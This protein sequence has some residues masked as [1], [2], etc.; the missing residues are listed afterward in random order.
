MTPGAS[1]GRALLNRTALLE[2]VCNSVGRAFLLASLSTLPSHLFFRH[3][4]HAP[5]PASALLQRIFHP[6]L[7]LIREIS[8][9]L[10]R[11]FKATL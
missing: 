1:P 8:N 7:R 9:V 3:S 10:S 11:I 6:I 2:I 4:R 5:S